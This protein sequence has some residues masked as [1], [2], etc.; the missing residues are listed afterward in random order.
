M[1]P[2]ERH[3]ALEALSLMR[4][5]GLSLTAAARQVD[6]TQKAVR[7]WV[8][9]AL[10]KPGAR[11]AAK[12]WD[13]ISR[14]MRVLSPQGL[15]E[16]EVRD[17]R[18]ASRNASYWNA[19]DQYLRTGNEELLRPFRGKSFSSRGVRY[20]F[21]TSTDVIERAA[22]VGQVEFEDLYGDSV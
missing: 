2:E 11:W 18:T 5:E 1:E 6:L 10:E 8:G 22:L 9:R 21:V 4:R 3:R 7:R 13:R 15:I 12:P 20:E 16:V 14:H 17:S 19:V